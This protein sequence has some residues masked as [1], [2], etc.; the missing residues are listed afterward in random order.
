LF[1][2]QGN[3]HAPRQ[4]EFPQHFPASGWVEHNPEDL[5]SSVKQTCDAVMAE[6]CGDRDEVIAVGITN[7]RETTVVW[8]RQTGEPVYNAIVWQDRRTASYCESLKSEG[9]EPWVSSKT[10][11]LVDPYFS[12]T[13][14]RWILENVAGVRE[15]AER[16]ELAFGTVDSFLLWRLTGGREHRTDATNASRTMLFNIHNQKW[17]PELLQLFDIPESLLPEVMD[18]ADQFGRITEGGALNGTSVLGVAGD[19][20]AALFGQ[21]CFGIGMAKSTY[22]TGCFLMLNTGDKALQSKHRLL[23]TVAYRVNGKPTYAL[24]G[25]IFIAGATIQW[26]RDGL[27]LIRDACETEPL[28]EGTP[29]DHGVYL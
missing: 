4:Q 15:R 27:R 10:G 22:G 29:V 17:D 14:L 26:L 11:L 19:Q 6:E 1:D 2:L 23:T 16:G 12:A 13:K 9:L 5:W 7:Q 8:D 21:T 25:S 3:I 20:Q 18:S 24:E 28:A